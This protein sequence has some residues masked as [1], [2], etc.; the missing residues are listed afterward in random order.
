MIE[1]SGTVPEEITLIHAHTARSVGVALC[2]RIFSLIFPVAV[3][4]CAGTSSVGM[5]APAPAAAVVYAA[6]DGTARECNRTTPCSIEA[7][8]Q[9]ERQILAGAEGA[10]ED[11]V[12]MLG[13]G[14]YRLGVPLRF[15]RE[16]SGRNGHTV[17]WR[18]ARGAHPVLSG[19]I[20]ATRWT[21]IDPAK[22]VWSAPLPAGIDTRQVYVDGV[23]APIAQTTPAELGVTFA[24][25]PGGYA[26]TPAWGATLQSRIG[27][28]AMARVEFVYTGATRWTQS[29]CRIASA[30]GSAIGMQQPCWRNVTHRPVYTQASGLMPNLPAGQAPSRI[31][32]AYPFLH[33]GQWFLDVDRHTLNYIPKP[34]QDIHLLDIEV[35]RLQ[36]LVIGSGTLDA[37]VHDIEF[38]GLQFADATWTGPGAPAGFSE[39]QDNL[40][41]TGADPAHPQATCTFGVPPGTCPFGSFSREPG[42]VE[43]TAARH[44]R[45]IGDTFTRLGAAGLVFEYG[46]RYNLVEGNF[47]SDI[48][49]NALIL[50][51]TTD[52]HPADVGADDREI[53]ADNT[54]D[55]NL[56]QRMG[57]DYPGA[58]AI[59]LFFTRRTR[60]VHNDIRDVPYTGISA[61]VIQGHVDNADH[62]DNTTNINADNTIS[63]NLIHG[64]MQTLQDGAAIY[65]EGHQGQAITS[66]AGS[67][68][69][70]ATIAHGLHAQGNV[71]WDEGHVN[72]TWYDDAGSEWIHWDG[73]VQWGG[74]IAQGGC[75]STGHVDVTG[76]Y[77]AQAIGQ[78]QCTAAIDVRSAD[79]TTI[80]ARPMLADLPADTL[81]DAGLQGDFRRLA[82]IRAPELS[83]AQSAGASVFLAGDG[84]VPGMAVTIGGAPAAGV[85]ILSPSFAVATLAAARKRA[86]T[87]ATVTVRTSAGSASTV[88]P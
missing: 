70:A 46:S 54:I 55:N 33:P 68:D 16:D 72:F 82:T 30:H 10:S 26:T 35:P 77:S 4:L 31:E 19:A 18:A 20:R 39:M 42:N 41:L 69:R 9:R 71:A 59:T 75:E 48:A 61:G 53:T 22:N 84:F 87:A 8:Q 60:V 52:P 76:M 38:R 24:A 78:Y 3:L 45:F 28:R 56:I 88:K 2:G 63:H 29:R 85:R 66:P 67:L 36:A 74:S 64:F 11:V 86:V 57:T 13:D 43:W 25:A 5:A 17:I 27:P 50:G 37:P 32:D 49:G 1:I 79:N 47:F 21:R 14:T 58:A 73:D 62:P 7:A 44:V 83:Y 81:A 34:G 65:V 23:E 6:P 51:N 40:R 12:I 80:P 15:G